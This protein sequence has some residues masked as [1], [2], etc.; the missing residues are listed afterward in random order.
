MSAHA[1]APPSPVEVTITTVLG[2]YRKHPDVVL[3]TAS[4]LFG[5]TLI[6]DIILGGLLLGL[7]HHYGA[8]MLLW[9]GSF[10][11]GVSVAAWNYAGRG[12]PR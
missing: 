7:H 9:L 5:L 4:L 8:Q 3:F 11:L 2:V 1:I 6:A 10:T 12:E